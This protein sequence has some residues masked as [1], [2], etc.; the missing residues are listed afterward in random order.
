MLL[1]REEEKM[2][3]KILKNKI[4]LEPNHLFLNKMYT[5][6]FV[7]K[8]YP[9]YLLPGML[10][11]FTHDKHV[12]EGVD[13]NFSIHFKKTSFQFNYLTNTKIDRLQN[14]VESF[15]SDKLSSVARKEE[16]LAL[17]GLLYLRD[18]SNI[19]RCADIWFTVTISSKS[20]RK[21]RKSIR[22]FKDTMVNKKFDFLD[23]TH[24]QHKA[25]QMAWMSGDNS[26]IMDLYK[27]RVMDQ[28]AIE[29]L[30]PYVDGTI[31]DEAS[32]VSAYIGHRIYDH[33]AVYKNFTNNPDN[34]NMIVTG[35]SD[36]GKSTFIKA[37]IISLLLCK[38]KGYVYDVDGEYENTCKEVGGA[39]VDYTADTG[40]YV[41]PTIIESAI[42]K[43]V[44]IDE[45]DAETIEKMRAADKK[46][47]NEAIENTKADISLLCDYFTVDKRNTLEYALLSM[48]ENAG[49]IRED[50]STWEIRDTSK[51][52]FHR[53]YDYIKSMAEEENTMH[54]SGAKELQKDL[55][56]Y[57]E[58]GNKGLFQNAT[59]TDWLKESPLT[60]F[61]VASEADSNVDQQIGAVKIVMITH[62]VW[63]QIKRDRIKKTHFSF[64]VYDE[65]QRLIKNPYARPP[66][67]RSIT[68]GRKFNDQVIMGFND[69]SILFPEN[70]GIWN[71]TKFKVF[72][73]LEKSMIEKLG[74]NGDMPPEVLDTWM[75]LP[76][77]S[78]I[79]R[80]KNQYD[81]LRMELSDDE[82]NRLSKTRGL[83]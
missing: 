2:N 62:M 8:E 44:N 39:W 75:N 28:Q 76:K 18:K 58:G 49:I 70:E 1:S 19:D 3:K 24:L 82:L 45:L 27:G 54:G 73:S 64:E 15:Q 38:F 72:F 48:W 9:Q 42:E 23:L 47:F 65:L 31:S 10:Y 26:Q 34:Q 55:W 35:T 32:E 66:L 40:K 50:D 57:F 69:P 7:I 80:E 81:V 17:E 78:F 6:T 51:V 5:Q 33:T 60:V 68:T 52:S 53:L 25:I 77:Y 41:D 21:F 71:N 30:Y 36:E 12:I 61:H 74:S 79:F 11:I 4:S 46:R 56:S 22:L 16:E 43:E 37:L 13:I 67:Y 63:Q 59:S 29:S 20:K 14:N 83:K